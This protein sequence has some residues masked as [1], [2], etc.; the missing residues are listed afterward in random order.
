MRYE[1]V[2]TK[3]YQYRPTKRNRT[4]SA[5]TSTQPARSGT[6]GSPVAGC[7]GHKNG[8]A[9][10]PT[11][12]RCR[13]PAHS[14]GG[15]GIVAA[16]WTGLVSMELCCMERLS[17]SERN[18][19][20]DRW[21]TGESQRSISRRSGRQPSTARTLLVPFGQPMETSSSSV[22]SPTRRSSTASNEPSP[23]SPVAVALVI[24]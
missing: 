14:G 6:H 18:E 7:A 2:P 21:E 11:P 3:H 9:L 5:N 13:Q 15:L 8:V 10:C 17:E 12:R 22:R 16:S 19:L 23:V 1:F 4:T 20:W 24:T